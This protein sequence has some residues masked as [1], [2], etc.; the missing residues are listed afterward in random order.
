MVIVKALLEAQTA[1]Q[2]YD[3]VP[4]ENLASGNYFIRISDVDGRTLASG[5]FMIVR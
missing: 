1:E 4:T 3:M 5:R 2:R